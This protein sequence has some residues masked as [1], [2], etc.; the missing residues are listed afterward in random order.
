VS[1][2]FYDGQLDVEPGCNR[3]FVDSASA[4]GGTGLRFLPVDHDGN[5]S[6]STAEADVIAELCREVLADGH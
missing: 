1:Q 6:A 2:R 5:A 4:L 3:Q